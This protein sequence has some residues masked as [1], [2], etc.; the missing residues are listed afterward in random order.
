[1]QTNAKYCQAAQDPAVCGSQ[2]LTK[3]GR[4]VK[5]MLLLAF[6]SELFATT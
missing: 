4:E 1:M 6:I 2:I 3:R 5:I